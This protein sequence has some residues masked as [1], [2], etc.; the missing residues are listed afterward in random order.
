V[1]RRVAIAAVAAVAALLCV[2]PADA[3]SKPVATS[4]F[5]GLS[6]LNDD[7]AL[8]GQPSN[9]LD[10]PDK[11]IV[12]EL[13]FVNHDGY[14]ISLVALEQTVALTVVHRNGKRRPSITTYLAHG[15]VT[16]NSIE[17][18]FADRGH[19]ALR[20]RPSGRKIHASRRAGCRRSS[21]HVIGRVGLF[22]GELRFRGEGG[23][24]SAEV[25]R[26][27]G[28]SIDFTALIACV[29][30]IPPRPDIS[31]PRP[32]L[33]LGLDGLGLEASTR[34]TGSGPSGVPTHPSGGPKPTVL[35]AE[36][37]SPLSRTIFAAQTHGQGRVRFL[38]MQASS[39]GSI[40]VLRL[41]SAPAPLSAF[42]VDDTLASA[43][44]KPPAPFKGK[45]SLEH[46]PSG[47]KS[48]TGSLSVSFLGAPHVPLTGSPFQTLLGR[49]F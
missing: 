16:P 9:P 4:F 39:E 25:H 1:R 48:W 38:A 10:L 23:Y 17:A 26:V 20:F 19:V 12:S 7:L 28:G 11:Q 5:S 6:H 24:T 36:S 14:T 43:G 40:G 35:I 45:A 32:K 3:A 22:V 46:G 13:R 42:A 27:H 29:L 15:K 34:K 41:V 2:Q 30:G 47:A 31:L 49:G 33:P 44:V 21:D 8:L 37:K 18:S